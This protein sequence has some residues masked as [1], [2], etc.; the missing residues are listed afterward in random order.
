MQ[1]YICIDDLN[2]IPDFIFQIQMR[3]YLYRMHAY[4]YTHEE[5]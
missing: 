2:F 5:C 4:D 1:I 3:C